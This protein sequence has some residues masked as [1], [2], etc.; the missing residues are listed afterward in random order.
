MLYAGV[1]VQTVFFHWT[2]QVSWTLSR[3]SANIVGA[4]L[5]RAFYPMKNIRA[6]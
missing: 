5:S 6:L 1:N 3:K 4:G 2:A